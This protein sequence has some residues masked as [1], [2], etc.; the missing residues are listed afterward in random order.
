MI[1]SNTYYLKITSI[2]RIFFPLKNK[3]TNSVLN[4]FKTFEDLPTNLWTDLGKE[5][6]NKSFKK[7]CEYNSINLY[8]TGG[9]SKAVFAERAIR[10]IKTRIT[11]III[12]NENY[13]YIDALKNIVE[14]YNNK[15]HS[16]VKQKPNDIYFNDEKPITEY[17]YTFVKKPKFNV[18][19]NVRISVVKGKFEKGYNPNWSKEIFKIIEVDKSDNP[20]MYQL[21]D[22]NHEAIKGKF[23]SEELQKTV[24]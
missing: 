11:E 9:E 13:R 8:H 6:I 14:Q 23:Y 19:D 10:T 3:E 12:E 22:L 7:W 16:S 21:Q 17:T 24:K 1:I 4:C 20:V 15:I 18:G 5:F 2:V